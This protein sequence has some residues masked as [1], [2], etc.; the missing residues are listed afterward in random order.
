MLA[1]HIPTYAL[2]SPLLRPCFFQIS[3]PRQPSFTHWHTLLAEK[4]INCSDRKSLLEGGVAG[5]AFLNAS[6]TISDLTK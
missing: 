3:S 5:V 2:A 1:P 4:W 6:K